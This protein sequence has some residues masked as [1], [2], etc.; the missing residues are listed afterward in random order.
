M[1][2]SDED[3]FFG[4]SSINKRHSASFTPPPQQQSSSQDLG[5]FDEPTTSEP[6]VP[7]PA[8]EAPKKPASALE[9]MMENSLFKVTHKAPPMAKAAAQPQP[10]TQ[11][12]QQPQQKPSQPAAPAAKESA[13][14]FDWSSQNYRDIFGEAEATPIPAPNPAIAQVFNFSFQNCYL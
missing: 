6:A 9:S 7:S 12:G 11:Q 5:F 8:P 1:Q 4:T 13:K 3:D 10:Q 14:K 2:P